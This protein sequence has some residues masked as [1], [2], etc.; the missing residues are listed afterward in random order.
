M[1]VVAWKDVEVEYEERGKAKGDE[2]ETYS[3][4][5]WFLATLSGGRKH[6]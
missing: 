4:S 3:P 1:A 5:I 6:R 2:E